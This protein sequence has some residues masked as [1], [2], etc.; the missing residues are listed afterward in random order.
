MKAP[1]L[2]KLAAFGVLAALVAAAVAEAQPPASAP[3][4]QGPRGPG[5]EG[6]IPQ[7]GG[8]PSPA[9]LLFHEIWNSTPMAQ[10]ITHEHLSNQN[11]ALHLYGD[12]AAIRKS[13]HP[14]ENYLYTGESVTN[15][16]LTFSDPAANWDLTRN[17][18]VKLKTRNSGY[19][20][21]HLMLKTADGKWYVS[22]EGAGESTYWTEVEY[23]LPDLH[24]RALLMTDTPTNASNRRQPDPKRTPIV[25]MGVARPDLSKVEE[26]GFTDLMP[27][28]WIPST[29]RVNA[30]DLYG[31]KVPR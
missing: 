15:W 26:I 8:D 7:M 5:G 18:K 27:G 31:K 6:G 4:R 19:R 12:V 20:F 24:W 10:P 11:L 22:E 30:F 13:V 1:S 17:G 16:G 29:T 28:G 25:A 9:P 2:P 14:I 21:T 3:A 23:I